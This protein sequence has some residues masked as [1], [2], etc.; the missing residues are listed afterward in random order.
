[1]KKL[2]KW[3]RGKTFTNKIIWT[4]IILFALLYLA[5]GFYGLVL[6]IYH[7]LKYPQENY[8][9]CFAFDVVYECNLVGLIYNSFIKLPY[10][11]FAFIVPEIIKN[12]PKDIINIPSG[13]LEPFH[14]FFIPVLIVIYYISI[15]ITVIYSIIRNKIKKRKR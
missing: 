3:W 4:Y 12:L 10:F 9:T 1:M 7:T 14:F 2:K 6:N 15:P 11:Y 8:Y 5:S 13:Y